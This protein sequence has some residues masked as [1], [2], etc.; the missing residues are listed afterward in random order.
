MSNTK[1][2]D[3]TN[4]IIAD[5]KNNT[6]TIQS[7]LIDVRNA[8]GYVYFNDTYRYHALNDDLSVITSNNELIEL[9]G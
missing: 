6:D 2:L 4:E 3:Y 7:G 9:G 8:D 1:R 5:L